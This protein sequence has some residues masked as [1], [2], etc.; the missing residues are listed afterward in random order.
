MAL[1]EDL[2]NPLSTEYPVLSREVQ[3]FDSYG[4]LWA[5]KLQECHPKFVASIR[6]EGVVEPV[7]L[8]FLPDGVYLAEGHHRWVAA[9]SLDLPVPWENAADRVPW[10]RRDLPWSDGYAAGDL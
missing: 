4:H 6:R 8:R 5:S 3:W 7:V 10:S 9:A 1:A 2:P